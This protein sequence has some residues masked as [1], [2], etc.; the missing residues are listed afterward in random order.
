MS[1]NDCIGKTLKPWPI[2]VDHYRGLKGKGFGRLRAEI[3]LND[4]ADWLKDW[5]T[6]ET[7]WNQANLPKFEDLMSALE[8]Q[9]KGE[10]Q[11]SLVKS[12]EI[13]EAQK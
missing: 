2:L 7:A 12:A 10:G 1:L 6:F 11:V 9:L 3:K 4:E 5:G 13:E 8:A